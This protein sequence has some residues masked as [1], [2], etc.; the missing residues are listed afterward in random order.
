MHRLLVLLATFAVL[1]PAQLP[2]RWVYVSR[3]LSSDQDVEDIRAIATT[4]SQHGY[5]AIALAAGLDRLDRQPAT[6]FTRLAQVKQICDRNNLEIIPL[7]FNVGYGSD[8]YAHDRNLAEGFPVNDALYVVSG[9][10]A[11]LTADPPVAFNNPS[12]ESYRGNT[13]TGWGF[14]DGPGTISFIDTEVVQ[15][16]QASLRFENIGASPAG[17][18]RLEQEVAVHPYR[19]YRVTFWV[20]TEALAPADGFAF[21][22]LTADGRTLAPWV[23][24]MSSTTDWRKVTWGFNSAGYD[25]VRIYAGVWGGQSGR[26]WLDNFQIEEV[27]LLNVLRRDGT[28]LT[29]RDDASDTIY[30]EGVDYLPIRDQQL[31]FTF[32]HDGPPIMIL[33][34]SAIADGQRLRV[35][36]YHGMATEDAQVSTCMSDPRLYGFWRDQAR[37]L[38]ALLAP[39][40]YILNFD[41]IR[42]GGSDWACKQRGMTMAQILGDSITQA[43][44]ILREVNPSAQ[45][46]SWSDMLDPTHNAHGNYYLVDGDFTGSWDYVP[47]DLGIVDWNYGQRR[48]SLDFF[49]SRGFRTVAGAYYDASTLD[50]SR[51]WLDALSGTP[52]AEGIMYTTWENKYGLLAAFG[53]MVSLPQ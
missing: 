8:V 29:V 14:N 10:Q 6:F 53:D 49:S 21:K 40:K 17:N 15:D 26:F 35:S 42:A 23:A 32:D 41:E 45:I 25:K 3:G 16:G 11:R 47:A 4:A 12:L 37:Q 27:G 22:V 7:I 20:K 13:V 44:N 2:N 52:G 36:Y 31:N 51:N 43:V 39:R 46:Y 38:D 18:A 34:G 9:N 28:P 5:T 24:N 30:T 33:P 19:H 50:S 48:A 1:L